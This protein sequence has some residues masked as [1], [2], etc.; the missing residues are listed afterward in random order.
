M[1]CGII[2]G[3]LGAITGIF[4]G[5]SKNRMLKKQ[6][7]MVNE[8]KRENQN[9]FD[10]KYNEDATQRADAQA[11]L[12]RTADMIKQRNR[13]AAGSAAVMGG[14]DESVAGTKAANA[15][16]MAN[17]ASQIAVSGA[18]RKDQIEAQYRGR[19]NQLDEQLRQLEA[20]KLNALDIAGGALGGAADG[21]RSGMELEL[22]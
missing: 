2:G 8:M 9:W 15:Q 21:Y 3:A 22:G 11:I 10:R 16:A 17:A 1:L 12:T 5:I 18:R 6:M 7:S 14:S 19:K 4:G 13:A 20:G